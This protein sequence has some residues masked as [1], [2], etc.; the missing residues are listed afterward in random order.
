MTSAN[1]IPYNVRITDPE[2]L[3][4][5]LQEAGDDSAQF[6]ALIRRVMATKGSTMRLPIAQISTGVE[7]EQCAPVTPSETPS[8]VSKKRKA[9]TPAARDFTEESVPDFIIK[10]I[11]DYLVVSDEPTSH[12]TQPFVDM[13]AIRGLFEKVLAEEYSISRGAKGIIAKFLKPTVVNDLIA[14]NLG[15]PLEK[16]IKVKL[17]PESFSAVVPEEYKF[18]ECADKKNMVT[19]KNVF[20]GVRFAD[21]GSF[22]T[23]SKPRTKKNTT[24]P[25]EMTSS[26]VEVSHVEGSNADDYNF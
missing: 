16:S 23:P 9:T 10:L 13:T 21:G 18:E 3:T 2:I 6:E 20:L 24:A 5:L 17:D 15:V 19:F 26:N 25:T 4:F 1:S 12:D 8:K 14:E 11:K 7:V 22:A